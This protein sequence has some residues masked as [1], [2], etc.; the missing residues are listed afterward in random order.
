MM[1][2]NKGNCHLSIGLF[3]IKKTCNSSENKLSF[4]PIL[5]RGNKS[6]KLENELTKYH[7][8]TQQPN[9]CLSRITVEFQRS[10]TDTLQSVEL[11]WT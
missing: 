3:G 4:S 5:E 10:Q 6:T 9:S 1:M 2:I 7:P 8:L 11:L